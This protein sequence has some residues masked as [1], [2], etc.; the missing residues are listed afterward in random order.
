MSD[1]GEELLNLKVILLGSTMADKTSIVSHIMSGP[2]DASTE[3]TVGAAYSV[4]T[5]SIGT[6]KMR[7]EMRDTACRERF[8]AFPR[9]ISGGASARLLPSP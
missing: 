3:A 1:P 2:F 9:S 5:V 6:I 7:L 4:K 8:K